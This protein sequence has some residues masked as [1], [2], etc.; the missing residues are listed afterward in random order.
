LESVVNQTY[1]MDSLEILVIDDASPDDSAD[2][3]RRFLAQHK[4]KSRVFSREKNGGAPASRNTGWKMATGDWIQFLDQDDLLSPHK[5][6]LQAQVASKSEDNVAVVYSNWQHLTLENDK[7]QPSGP[8]RAP[9]VDDDPLV[10]ILEQTDFGYVGPT[11]IRRSFMERLGG[12]DEKPNLGEDINL[13]LRLAMAGGQ[14]REARSEKVAFLYRQSPNSLWRTYI[15]NIEPMRNL[16]HGIHGAE[17]F[18]RNQ[19]PDRS[20]SEP[21]RHALAYRYS[22]FVDFYLQHDRES[23]DLVIGWL[24]GMN[25]NGPP[26]LPARFRILSNLIGYDNVMRLREKLGILSKA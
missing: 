11:L 1:P 7:W 4:V 23:Y 24:K 21:A 12:F 19:S 17:E 5:I 9:F 26:N 8:V 22:R 2:I 15:K 3:A 6:E 13:M 20:L 14:F 18:L 25:F 16:L 10:K